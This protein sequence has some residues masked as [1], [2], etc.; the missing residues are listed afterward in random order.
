MILAGDV[1]G[2]KV[3]LAVCTFEEGRLLIQFD[4]KYPAKEYKTLRDIVDTFLKEPE[5]AKL[6]G[7]ITSAC[8]GAP[9]PVREGRIQL[10]NLPWLLDTRV[11]SKELNIE[12]L[13]LINDLEAN[14]Y[15]IAELPADAIAT[16]H[17]GDRSAIGHRSL[18]SAGTGL[19]QAQ[20]VWNAQTGRFLPLA[21]E[22]GHADFAARTPLEI[23]MLQFLIAKY[24]GRISWER[25]ISGLGLQNVY[26]FL[27]DGKKMEEPKW[28]RDE[29]AAGD[30]NVAITVHGQDGSSEICAKTLDIFAGAYGAQAG[31]LALLLLAAG[32]VYLG[33]GIPPKI[34]KTLQNGTFRQAFLD[35]GRLSPLNETIPVRVILEQRCALFGAAAYAEMRS[36][37]ISGRS[38]RVGSKSAG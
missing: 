22:G 16:L 38:E 20:L 30:P 2:T 32:G 21:S 15:G 23:E 27:R 4:K 25:V 13:F 10:T 33:G 18:I 29:M 8:F 31:N 35:K 11:L 5:A 24:N 9:G 14:A 34:M 28:L 7:G 1:G 3:H 36:A 6:E 37:E 19:G 26:S 12:H 17:E